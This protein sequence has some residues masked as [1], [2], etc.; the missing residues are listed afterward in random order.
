MFKK[1]YFVCWVGRY[2]LMGTIIRNIFSYWQNILSSDRS[3]LVSTALIAN[4]ELARRGLMSYY[5]KIKGLLTVLNKQSYIHVMDRQKVRDESRNLRKC[6][7]RMYEDFF[8]RELECKRNNQ[9][10]GKFTIY[11]KV[12]KNYVCEKYIHNINCN[13]MRRHLTGIRCASNLMPVNLLRK[14]NVPKE[15]RLCNL[16]DTNQ[17]GDELHIV[18]LCRNEHLVKL[19]QQL[20][21]IIK[22][23][24]PQF[25]ILNEHQKF[26]Y[27]L[28]CIE[29]KI[30]HHFAI[31]LE[32]IQ[33]ILKKKSSK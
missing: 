10:Q 29:Q 21:N 31:F 5:S 16:C 3:S 25:A 30:N 24:S 7:F 13:K 4:I 18:I 22:S 11:C 6:Y 15:N 23:F 20:F 27:L 9:S 8:F 26:I 28:N 17:I 2:P 14:K 32:K 12:K 33:K 1:R 19:R